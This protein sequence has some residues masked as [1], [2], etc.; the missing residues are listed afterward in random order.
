MS[1]KITLI[2]FDF[3]NHLTSDFMNKRGFIHNCLMKFSFKG[4]TSRNNFNIKVKEE[5][6]FLK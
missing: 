4:K 5:I 1:K 3:L 6:T 2:D